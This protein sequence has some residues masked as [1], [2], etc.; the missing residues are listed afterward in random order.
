M[1]IQVIPSDKDVPLIQDFE[2]T[3]QE[4]RERAEAFFKTAQ[5]LEEA[6]AEVTVDEEAQIG[7]AHV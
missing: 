7:R 5:L 1:T 3:P 6:G 4:I 2:G